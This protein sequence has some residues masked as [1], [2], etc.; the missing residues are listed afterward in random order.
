MC[1]GRN[2]VVCPSHVD[3]DFE[4]FAPGAGEVAVP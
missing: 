4:V 3:V 1:E 2:P